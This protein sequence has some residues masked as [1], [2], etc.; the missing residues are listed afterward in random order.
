MKD[1]MYNAYRLINKNQIN[2]ILV[3]KNKKIHS[4]LTLHEINES[5]SPERL[6]LDKKKL[7]K[8]NLDIKKHLIR[9]NFANLFVK[10]ILKFWMLLAESGMEQIF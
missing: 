10:K 1:T 8:F 9:Y 4:Y 5:L 3:L 6:N 7:I 2:C